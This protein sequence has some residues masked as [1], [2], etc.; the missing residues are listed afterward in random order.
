MKKIIWLPVNQNLN[1]ECSVVI[2]WSGYIKH[3]WQNKK[4]TGFEHYPAIPT[5]NTDVYFKMETVICTF[6]TMYVQIESRYY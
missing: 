1:F 2:I 4:T 6:K 5:K 3:K